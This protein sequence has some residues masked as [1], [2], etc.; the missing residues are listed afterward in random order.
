MKKRNIIQS[1]GTMLIMSIMLTG[2]SGCG[3]KKDDTEGVE[4][5]AV[6]TESGVKKPE[7][8]D[9]VI[10]TFKAADKGD[11][12]KLDNNNTVIDG[13]AAFLDAARTSDGKPY[14]LRTGSGA[15]DYITTTVT[16]DN[17]LIMQIGSTM[18]GTYSD[19]GLNCDS[20]TAKEDVNNLMKDIC[21][22]DTDKAVVDTIK[23]SQITWN[24]NNDNYILYY[25]TENNYA[26]CVII[27]RTSWGT[28]LRC[29]IIDTEGSH[30]INELTNSYICTF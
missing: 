18:T 24:D 19:T 12:S 11:T 15:D 13:Y 22:T 7:T 25:K 27:Q 4:T 5:E 29:D 6:E 20:D 10:D 30:N 17:T 2:C 9:E 3:N 23:V 21:D 16:D 14:T 26:K 1:I 28:Y 8:A